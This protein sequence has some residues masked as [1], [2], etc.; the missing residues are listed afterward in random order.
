MHQCRHGTRPHWAPPPTDLATHMEHTRI[1]EEKSNR[2]D[3]Q[4]CHRHH[5]SSSERLR[6]QVRRP[7]TQPSPQRRRYPCRPMPTVSHTR[8]V[9]DSFDFDEEFR[10]EKYA[11]LAPTESSAN[12]RLLVII[13]TRTS[14]SQL[15]LLSNT[16]KHENPS[17]TPENRLRSPSRDPTSARRIIVAKLPSEPQEPSHQP[18]GQAAN[19]SQAIVNSETMPPRRS[20]THQRLH[21]P[22]Q[23]SE[24]SLRR[25]HGTRRGALSDAS[26][27]VSGTRECR[28]RRF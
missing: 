19:H 18:R 13:A 24:V 26:K 6:L 9:T 8:Q 3:C 21:H 25:H 14:P 22:I 17:D 12:H 15:R 28:R 7:P 20:K 5:S 27:K 16:M 4:Q 1:N 2:R 10:K 11:G 23:G